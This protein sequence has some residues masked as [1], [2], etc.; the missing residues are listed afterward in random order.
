MVM[1]PFMKQMSKMSAIKQT[2]TV[3]PIVKKQV[4]VSPLVVGDDLALRTSLT[5]PVFYD[6]EMVKLIHKHSEFI[7][8]EDRNITYPAFIRNLSNVDKLSLLWALFKSTYETLGK[9]NFTCTKE[10]CEHQKKPFEIEVLLDDIIHED[11]YTPWE[12]EAPFNEYVYQIDIPYENLIYSFQ[13]RLPSIE[14]NNRILSTMSTD[15]L[16]RNLE[17]LGTVYS[18]AQNLSLLISAMQLQGNAENTE[19]ETVQTDNLQEMLMAF[20]SYVPYRVSEQFLEKYG[21]KF[22][23]YL[24]RFYKTA[25]CPSC[26]EE[27]RNDF[28]LEV[29]FFRRSLFS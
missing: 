2:M 8:E 4:N 12:E 1:S 5:S 11:T 10:N 24:P 28:D 23:K 21:E 29:E 19:F 3:L 7:E 16:Q 17:N 26:G 27:V 18:R 14:A 15:S 20:N 25:K 13:A 6:K 22:D 9:R